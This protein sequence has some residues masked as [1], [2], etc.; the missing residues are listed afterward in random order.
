MGRAESCF[1]GRCLCRLLQTRIYGLFEEIRKENKMKKAFW[2]LIGL[3]VASIAVNVW[4]WMREPK[5]VTKIE[6]RTDTIWRDTAIEKPVP[7]DLT[8]TCRVEQ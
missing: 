8:Q 1:V 7:T 2:I 6:T 3:L 4:L 5:E